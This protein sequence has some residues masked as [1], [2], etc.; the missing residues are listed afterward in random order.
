MRNNV[1]AQGKTKDGIGKEAYS[2]FN[3]WNAA[4]DIDIASDD[5]L[6]L[7]DS[8]MIQPRNPDGSIPESDFLRLAPGSDAI[9]AGVDVGL[10]FVGKAPDLGASEYDPEKA[11]RQS[12]IKWLHQAVRDHD[13]AKIQSIL[14][15]KADVNEKDWLGYAPLHWACYFGYADVM[16]L[17][18]DRKADPNLLSDTGRRPLEIAKAMDYTELAGLLRKHGAKE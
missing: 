8:T 12:G 16:E 14:S 2:Q 7:D 17:L 13:I 4:L 10:P 18:L 6:S 9:D 15:K 5:F 11:K 3:S 1:S